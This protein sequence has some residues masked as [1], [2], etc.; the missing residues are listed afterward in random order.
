M[1]VAIFPDAL[2]LSVFLLV[3][4]DGVRAAV[5]AAQTPAHLTVKYRYYTVPTRRQFSTI[6]DILVANDFD[7]FYN[8]K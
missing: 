7:C 4:R 6:T 3:A 5:S 1:L 2:A 8:I